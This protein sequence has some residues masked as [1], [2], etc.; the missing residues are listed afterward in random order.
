VKTGRL[1]PHRSNQSV[2]FAKEAA[3]TFCAGGRGSDVFTNDLYGGPSIRRRQTT[4]P[5]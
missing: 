2:I 1:L 5:K 4:T 3:G